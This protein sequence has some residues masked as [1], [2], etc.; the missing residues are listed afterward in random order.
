VLSC[1]FGQVGEVL[2]RESARVGVRR[3]LLLHRTIHWLNCTPT[4]LPTTLQHYQQSNSQPSPPPLNSHLFR[5]IFRRCLSLPSTRL[6]SGDL[7]LSGVVPQTTSLLRP[8]LPPLPPLP[9]APLS[10]IR[11][12]LRLSFLPL[13]RARNATRSISVTRRGSRCDSP[14]VLPFLSP[15]FSSP[16]ER[17]ESVHVRC[18]C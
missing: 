5:L 1:E 7:L 2:G 18:K 8:L 17:G 6:S 12:H 16:L 15:S 4:H 10:A 13:S 14:S 11:S 3:L 9:L